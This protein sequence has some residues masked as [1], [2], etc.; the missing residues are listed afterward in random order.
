VVLRDDV[1][2]L[3]AHRREKQRVRVEDVAVR[4]EVNDCLVCRDRGDLAA[5]LGE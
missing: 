1:I 2:E 3:I 5:Q 4:R